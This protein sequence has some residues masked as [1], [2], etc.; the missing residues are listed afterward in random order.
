MSTGV[1]DSAAQMQVKESPFKVSSGI[2]LNTA[3]GNNSLLNF[4]PNIS[5]EYD[6]G[7]F[8]AG[9]GVIYNYVRVDGNEVINDY[10]IDNSFNI[11]PPNSPLEIGT[12]L[13]Q[14][15]SPALGV[16][17]RNSFGFGFGYPIIGTDDEGVKLTLSAIRDQANYESGDFLN[18][19]ITDPRRVNYG[20]M[21]GFDGDHTFGQE[22][23]MSLGYNFYGFIPFANSSENRYQG[24][25][26]LNIPLSGLINFQTGLQW[27]YDNLTLVGK[28]H[29]NYFF[30]FGF[31]VSPN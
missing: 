28:E 17:S 18:Q 11:S 20:P 7:V 3:S 23:R 24:N 10:L 5:A 21:I 19:N 9:L 2:A 29:S 31:S 22:R 26:F 27:T 25:A 13:Q 30:N 1:I 15:V 4:T 14:S 6:A 12:I 8:G 16:D